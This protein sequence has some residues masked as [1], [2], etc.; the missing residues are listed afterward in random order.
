M[1]TTLVH[2]LAAFLLLAWGLPL[3]AQQ[4]RWDDALDRYERI[5]GDCMRLRSIAA[6][7][8]AV[9][10]S[11]LSSLVSELASLRRTLKAAEGSM[12]PQQ[13]E[14]FL[15]IR[16][17]YDSLFQQNTK[18][19]VSL[20]PCARIPDPRPL[21]LQ[22]KEAPVFVRAPHYS[23]IVSAPQIHCGIVALCGMPEISPGVIV[24]A[25]K[26]SWGAYLKAVS[27]ISRPAVSGDCYSDGTTPGGG[28][29]WTSGKA[30]YT[31]FSI[32]AGAV[33]SILPVAAIYAGAG[34]GNR[35][36]L[37]QE[38][39]GTWMRVA[40]RSSAGVAADLGILLY[41]A[42]SGFTILAGAST[43]GFRNIS[44]EIGLGW[45]F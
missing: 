27:S 39:S 3:F 34:Y 30:M 1:K 6:A 38:A 18:K 31:R 9:S 20:Y 14:R 2:I 16:H 33:W 7:G 17:R 11:E 24:F 10:G 23:G 40:D 13:S 8:Q 36:E 41:P 21:I 26:N 35:S 5:C 4:N 29:I 45:Q 28:Y 25:G 44:A 42:K 43:V 19:A 37:W 12:S 15:Q 22:A 32:S